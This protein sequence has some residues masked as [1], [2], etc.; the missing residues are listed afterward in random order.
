MVH[1]SI[2][3][4]LV[5]LGALLGLTVG[6]FKKNDVGR[7]TRSGRFGYKANDSFRKDSIPSESELGAIV[8]PWSAY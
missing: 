2:F 4:S 8:S 5:G 1:G 7:L 3:A 6:R